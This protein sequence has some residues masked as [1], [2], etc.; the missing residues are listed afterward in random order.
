MNESYKICCVTGH[1]PEG[2]PWDYYD[3]TNDSQKEYRS[4]LKD[5]VE[6]YIQE[7]YN[8]FLSGGA[9]GVD[10]DFAETVLHLREKYL[11]N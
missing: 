8:Y 3:E 5:I 7:G 2:F 10:L 1:R 4:K 9:R 11:N 6:R